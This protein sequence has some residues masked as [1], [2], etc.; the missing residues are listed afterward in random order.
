MPRLLH[1]SVSVLTTDF[2]S[3]DL[4]RGV[5]VR[6]TEDSS[7]DSKKMRRERANRAVLAALGSGFLLVF[8]GQTQIE[9]VQR[10][11]ALTLALFVGGA[12]VGGVGFYMAQRK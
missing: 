2:A 10:S 9:A 6:V 1:T 8:L 7:T 12:V 11:M 3:H 4:G 5:V